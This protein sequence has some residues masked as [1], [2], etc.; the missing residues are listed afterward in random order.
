MEN[1]AIRIFWI[2]S[3][4]NSLYNA[5]NVFDGGFLLLN[6]DTFEIWKTAPRPFWPANVDYGAYLLQVD[7]GDVFIVF[8]MDMPQ[9]S[10]IEE[11]QNNGVHFGC[12]EEPD[13]GCSLYLVKFENI[14][15][16][17][18]LD[19]ILYPREKCDERLANY[20]SANQYKMLLIDSSNGLLCASRSITAPDMLVETMYI[21]LKLAYETTFFSLKYNDFIRKYKSQTLSFLWEKSEKLGIVDD[22]LLYD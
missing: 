20:K 12:I 11:I 15:F 17:L 6:Y 22:G 2:C 5:N 19:P 13:N 4:G 8:Y 9:E 10:E 21:N 16:D 1:P 7:E 3:G 18:L 14:V